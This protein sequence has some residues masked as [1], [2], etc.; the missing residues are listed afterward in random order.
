MAEPNGVSKPL[1]MSATLTFTQLIAWE[2]LIDFLITKTLPNMKLL[3]FLSAEYF[4][5]T[6]SEKEV[7]SV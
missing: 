1:D 6:L 3:M 4:L 7:A 5:A 2:N